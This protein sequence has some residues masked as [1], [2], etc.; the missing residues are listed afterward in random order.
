MKMHSSIAVANYLLAMA[1]E[2]DRVFNPLQLVKLVYLCHGWMLGLHG[3]PL[4]KENI[5]AYT[6]GPIIPSLYKKVKNYRS[7]PVSRKLWEPFF[8]P[9]FTEQEKSIIEQVY[10]Q[11]GGFSGL[12]LS[13]LTHSV[14][15]AWDLTKKLGHD[16]TIPDD[17]IREDFRIQLQNF[18]DRVEPTVKTMHRNKAS[19]QLEIEPNE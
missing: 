4:I 17:L 13:T 2:H 9:K 1:K 10:K 15:S 7:K 18:C 3:K 19:Y 8:E 11:Y 16:L 14:D 5:K 6:Y 12:Q